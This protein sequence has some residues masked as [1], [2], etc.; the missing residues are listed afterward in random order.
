MRPWEGR[1][2]RASGSSGSQSEVSV[3]VGSISVAETPVPRSSSTSTSCS[4]R[5]PNLAAPYAAFPGNARR[6]ATEPTFTNRPLRR[7]SMLG[8]SARMTRNGARRFRAK[9]WSNAITEVSTSG[10]RWKEPPAL[11]TAVGGPPI[12]SLNAYSALFR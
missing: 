3:A 12:V 7:A 10:A 2:S 5:N 8:S 1:S 6:P 11:T 4:P 9:L